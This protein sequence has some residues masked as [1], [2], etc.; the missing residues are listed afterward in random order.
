MDIKCINHRLTEAERQAFHR[1]GYFIVENALNPDHVEQLIE[2]QERVLEKTR[3][4]DRSFR[5]GN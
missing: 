2:A 5:K 1:D 3:L 4:A